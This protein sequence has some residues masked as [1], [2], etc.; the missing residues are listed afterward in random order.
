[1]CMYS[2]RMQIL[3][4]PDQR[5]R[6]EDEARLRGSSVASLVR[7]ALDARFGGVT[8]DERIEAARRMTLREAEYLPPEELERLIDSRFDDDLAAKPRGTRE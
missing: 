4:S 6:L 8:R 3:L 1:M 7:E 5:R 2:E